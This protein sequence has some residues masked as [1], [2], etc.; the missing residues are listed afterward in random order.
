[1]RTKHTARPP[2]RNGAS[3][4]TTTAT[5]SSTPRVLSPNKPKDLT[6]QDGA[7][8]RDFLDRSE[9]PFSVSTTA[10]S[11]KRK[12]GT[13]LLTEANLW[14]DR[15]SVRY[16]VKPANNWMSLK[17]YKKFTV[18]DESIGVGEC[19][20]VKHQDAD[21]A[22]AAAANR[23]DLAAQWKAKVLEVRAL[24]P[25]HVY[26]RVAWLN[27]PEDLES[28]RKPYHGAN[29]LIPTNHLDIIDA[30][31]INGQLHLYHWLEDEDDSEVPGIGEHFWRQTYDF[32]NT[33]TFSKLRSICRDES[34]QN[35]DKMILQCDNA[36]C[37]KWMHVQCIIEDAVTRVVGPDDHSP[38]SRKGRAKPV[39]QQKK[40][41]AKKK[42]LRQD[43]A[44][45]ADAPLSPTLPAIAI[46]RSGPY[47]AELFVKGTPDGPDSTPAPRTEIVITDEAG[48]EGRAQRVRCLVCGSTVEDND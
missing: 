26:I 46:A 32:A 43:E 25:E 11:K 34:P 5:S 35:P 37:R 30:M 6:P 15:L 21:D 41:K 29:E 3:T 1:M 16:E 9:K 42:K 47:T 2:Q 20:L 22:A 38:A 14:E 31:T 36:E 4:T 19:I 12:R 48:G 28:G 39:P 40:E 8:L 44:A 45:E 7:K 10:I 13:H 17:G 33:K 27:R 18:G 23:V 24:D